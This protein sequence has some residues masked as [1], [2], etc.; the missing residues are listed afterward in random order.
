[1]QPDSHAQCR[2]FDQPDGCL[3]AA[4]RGSVEIAARHILYHRTANAVGVGREDG[5][6]AAHR[7]RDRIA[8]ALDMRCRD[9]KAARVADGRVIVGHMVMRN[10]RSKDEAAS[11]AEPVQDGFERGAF[12]R[13]VD[14]RILEHPELEERVAFDQNGGNLQVQEPILVALDSADPS[15]D[16]GLRRIDPRGG[17]VAEQIGVQQILHIEPRIIGEQLVADLH[18]VRRLGR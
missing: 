10:V 4:E 3:G 9:K 15:E 5:T 8:E 2:I 13:L 7:F 12:V 11:K 14:V 17:A 16:R 18:Q 6:T 1:M